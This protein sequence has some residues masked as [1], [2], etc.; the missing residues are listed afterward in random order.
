MG[1]LHFQAAIETVLTLPGGVWMKKVFKWVTIVIG[2]DGK[3][4]GFMPSQEFNHVCNILSKLQ[5]ADRAEAAERA[6]EAGL[7]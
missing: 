6:R 2:T 3:S 4:L 1:S 5:V 7:G